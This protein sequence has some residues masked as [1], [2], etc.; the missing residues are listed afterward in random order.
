MVRIVWIV[1]IIRQKIGAVLMVLK[2]RR[3]M[4]PIN[5]ESGGGFSIKGI[6]PKSLGNPIKI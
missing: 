1:G 5:K 3:N 2:E 6:A 4:L